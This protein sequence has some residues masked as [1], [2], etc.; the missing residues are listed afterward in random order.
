MSDILY[1]AILCGD[2]VYIDT[3]CANRPGN[4]KSSSTTFNELLPGGSTPLNIAISN[5]R[6][7]V[8]R[9]LLDRGANA[10]APDSFRVDGCER[11]PIHYACSSGSLDLVKELVEVH[12]V[13]PEERDCGNSPPIHHAAA[14]GNIG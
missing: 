9:F 7:E 11:K 5:K 12:G 3:L 10:D 14:S 8:V 1:E 13:D 4:N 6:Y 2:T